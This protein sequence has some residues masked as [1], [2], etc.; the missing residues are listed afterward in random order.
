MIFNFRLCFSFQLTE[1]VTITHRPTEFIWSKWEKRKIEFYLLSGFSILYNFCSFF[2]ENFHFNFHSNKRRQIST[3][4][5]YEV[6]IYQKLT[7]LAVTGQIV[8]SR[9]MRVVTMPHGHGQKDRWGREQSVSLKGIST[10]NCT[11]ILQVE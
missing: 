5:M 4:W 11:E 7:Q 2:S 6:S 1:C 9:F 8:S 3:W 10:L